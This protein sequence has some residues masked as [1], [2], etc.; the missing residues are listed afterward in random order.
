MG[1]VLAFTLAESGDAKT[2]TV[3]DSTGTGS[4]GWGGAN[5]AVSSIDSS[6]NKLTLDIIITTSDGVETTYDQIDL[7][8]EFLSH[9][10]GDVTDLV[11][12]IT[13]ANLKVSAAPIGTAEDQLPD[14]LYDIEYSWSGTGANSIESVAL[15][16]G[17]IKKNL[18]ELIRTIPTKYE[19]QDCY[20]KDILDIIFA[21]G[22]Y[23][24]L[25][26]TATVGREDDVINQLVVLERLLE[27]G[28]NY[29]W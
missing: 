22:Y 2:L 3:T 15:I 21:K 12:P 9:S 17:V 1:F 27:N 11:F 26:A 7:H 4:T 10:H 6:S 24:A 20:D 28:S 13:C 8:T 19:S 16:D 5:P 29:T 23:D 14:G 18:Y 25:V